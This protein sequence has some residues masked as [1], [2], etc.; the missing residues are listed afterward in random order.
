MLWRSI[1]HHRKSVINYLRYQSLGTGWRAERRHPSIRTA[2]LIVVR[3]QESLGSL[4]G[5]P[6]PSGSGVIQHSKLPIVV[7]LLECKKANGNRF[8]SRTL[9]PES[10]FQHL[11]LSLL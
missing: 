2:S 3:S 9:W 7:H 10:R 8:G 4:V 1:L 5:T 11:L 6:V